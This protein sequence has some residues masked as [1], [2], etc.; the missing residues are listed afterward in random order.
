MPASSF[1]K[2]TARKHHKYSHC[3]KNKKFPDVRQEKP[4]RKYD[5]YSVDT[6]EN[7]DMVS[8]YND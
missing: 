2:F 4:L 7:T 1:L 3:R 8:I 6:S 5:R